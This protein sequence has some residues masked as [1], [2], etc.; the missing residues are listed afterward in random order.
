MKITQKV[1]FYNNF[2]TL[3]ANRALFTLKQRNFMEKNLVEMPKWSIWRVFG[4]IVAFGQRVLPDKSIRQ[5]L[6]ENAKI[7]IRHFR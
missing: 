5:M 1:S 7:Q 2:T 4:K 6:M 3:R